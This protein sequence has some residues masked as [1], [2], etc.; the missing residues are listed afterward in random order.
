MKWF[1]GMA[2]IGFDSF[3][4]SKQAVEIR[5]VGGLENMPQVDEVFSSDVNKLLLQ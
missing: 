5:I 4:G 2:T 1:F 3:D